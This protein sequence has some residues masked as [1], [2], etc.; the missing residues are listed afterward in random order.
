LTTEGRVLT[1]SE[2]DAKASQ[3]KQLSGRTA[4]DLIVF[5]DSPEDLPNAEELI[6]TVQKVHIE[7]SNPLNLTGRVSQV[8]S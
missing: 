8:I 5:F 3:I 6:G 4:G 7:G 1:T 2:N